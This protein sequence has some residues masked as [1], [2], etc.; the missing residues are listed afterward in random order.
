MLWGRR[1]GS[2]PAPAYLNRIG[3]LGTGL[4]LNEKFPNSTD[5]RGLPIPSHTAGRVQVLAWV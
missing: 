1:F 2:A 5:N 4:S 3:R